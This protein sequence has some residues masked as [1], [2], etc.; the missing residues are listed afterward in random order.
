MFCQPLPRPYLELYTLLRGKNFALAWVLCSLCRYHRLLRK[1]SKKQR[2][3]MNGEDYN[4]PKHVFGQPS[5][6]MTHAVSAEASALDAAGGIEGM[7]SEGS[8][9]PYSASLQHTLKSGID[10]ML[11]R[12]LTLKHSQTAFQ[13][14]Q[15]NAVDS[16]CVTQ[17]AGH[18]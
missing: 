18:E 9:I 6:E 1:L 2:L 15:R 5:Q 12:S 13:H 17:T 10:S 3:K 7:H 11:L 4:A 16:M 8:G 14:H